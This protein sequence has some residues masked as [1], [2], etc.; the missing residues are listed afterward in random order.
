[1]I[2]TL[3][4][5]IMAVLSAL[6]KLAGLEIGEEQMQAVYDAVLN[7]LTVAAPIGVIIRNWWAKRKEK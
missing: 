1:M 7:F 2:K 4:L 6:L 3:P 5:A